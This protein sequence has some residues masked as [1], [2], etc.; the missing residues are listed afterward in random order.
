MNQIKKNYIYNVLYQII[1]IILPFVT[2]PYV[3]RTIG[4]EGVGTYSYTYSIVYYFILISMLGISN[5]GTRE[6]AKF[7][8]DKKELSIK[9]FS[10]YKL[11]LIMSFLMIISYLLYVFIFDVAYKDIAVIQVIYLFASIFDI[12]W[13]FFG[14][15]K[16]K[17]TVS[18][19][20]LIKLLSFILI[21]LLVKDSEDT[22]V[23]TVILSASTLISRFI[24]W[25]MAKKYII[26]EYAKFARIKGHV[27][28]IIIL[29]IPV[30]AYSIYKVMDKIML[31][32]MIDVTEVGYYEN[33]DKL[34]NMPVSLITALGTVM[35]PRMAHIIHNNKNNQM[36]E[37]INNSIRFITFL[38]LPIV[39][40]FVSIGRDFSE[41]FFGK[42]FYKTGTIILILAPTIVFVA[43]ANVIRTQYLIPKNN[44]KIYVISTICGAVI[45]LII[46]LLLIPKYG[47][48]GAAVGTIFAEFSVMMY[49]VIAIRKEIPVRNYIKLSF[50]FLVSSIIMYAI[51]TCVDL[52][53]LNQIYGLILKVLLGI[54]VYLLLN[55][56]YIYKNIVKN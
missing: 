35:L 3:S 40:G 55:A 34:I 47:S 28:E 15:E 19:N 14:L 1:V 23:Y 6:I 4:V 22:W 54:G 20:I 25:F 43:I 53:Q 9:F 5:Y 27:R 38:V 41:I 39:F 32:S 21:L 10:I 52:L 49:Q 18:R 44:N 56:K 30:I 26:I 8:D 16:F 33:A 11:Q 17:I 7:R 42:E 29:F 13:L 48:Y 37:Y 2:V 51:I 50:D 24:F 46:N 12:T 31:G 36:N 45:N